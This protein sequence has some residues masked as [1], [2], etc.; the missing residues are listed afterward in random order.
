MKILFITHWYPNYVPDL[1]LHGLRKLMGPDVVDFPRKDCLYEGV[2]GLGVCPPDQL[3]PGLP[4]FSNP[5]TIR[6]KSTAMI[7]GIKPVQAILT[8]WSATSGPGPNW[9]KIWMGAARRWP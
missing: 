9:L 8:C 2:L 3:C 5:Q 6:E 7:S 1:L 4:V